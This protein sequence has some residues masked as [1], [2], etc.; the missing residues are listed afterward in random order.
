MED[1][2]DATQAAYDALAAARAVADKSSPR[3]Q[4]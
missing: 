2:L 4:E 1:K 3:T